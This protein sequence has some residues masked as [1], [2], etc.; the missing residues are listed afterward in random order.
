[1]LWDKQAKKKDA[2][3]LILLGSSSLEIQHG[4]T[5]SLAGRFQTHFVHHWS[6][7]ES[8]DGYG[9]NL[10]DYLIY[11]GYPGSYRFIHDRAEWLQYMRMSIINP[12]IGKDI[13]TQHRVK[14]PALFRQCF[15]IICS[16]PAQ[17][18]SYTKL[19]GQL[20]DRGNTDLIK[21]YLELF[22]GAF[23]IKQVPKYSAKALISRTSS[24][25]IL[26]M[27]PA[28][29]AATL[30]ADLNAEQRGRSFELTVGAM[31]ARLPGHLYYWR[32]GND[33][34]DYI[35]EYGKDLYALEVKS[36]RKKSAH[37]LQK[38]V[39]L[40]PNAQAI[41]VTPTNFLSLPF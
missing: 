22:E 35:Y 32:Q 23:L 34:V 21:H 28:L 38:F 30:D 41:I 33:E 29:Y 11:G 4:L 6:F 19:L 20:Q 36:G 1:M 18:I 15:D 16:Y 9:L 3:K 7:P 24:P 8:R 12:V 17:E 39:K 37:G 13:L 14:S 26:P 10:D 40:Y 2:L 27:C 25:K 5:E 31:L